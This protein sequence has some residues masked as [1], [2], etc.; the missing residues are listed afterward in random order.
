LESAKKS[1]KA[2]KKANESHEQDINELQK[3]LDTVIQR[4]DEYEEIISLET[5]SQ[6]SNMQLEDSKVKE[7]HRLKEEAGTQAASFLQEL[8]SL[9]REQKMDQDKLDN[10]M[11]KKNEHEAQIKQKEHELEECSQRTEKLNEYIRSSK[12][13]VEEQKK[14]EAT[15]AVDV[16]HARV[17][18][19]EIQT[20]LESVVEQLGEAKVDKHESARAVKR[21]ELIDNLKRLFP[22]VYGRLIDLCEPSHKKYQVAIT[23]VLGKYMDAIACDSEKTAKD[24]IQYMKEQ[25]IEPETFLPLDYV[26]VKPVNEKL[27]DINDPKNVKLVVDVIRYDPPCIKKALL[28]ACGNALVCETVEDAR[29]VAFN[30]SERHK[31][32]SLDGTLFQKSGVI[33]GGASDL[34]AKARRWDEKQLNQLKTKK[35]KLTDELKEQMKQKR[36]ESELNTIRSQI[37]GLET[38]LK[39][40]VTDRDNMQNKSIQQLEKD[41]EDNK[42]KTKSTD[43]EI[44]RIKELLAARGAKLRVVKDKMDTVEDRV[45][46]QFCRDINVENIRQYEERELQVQEE[47][48]QKR[49]EFDNQKERLSNQLEFEKSRD[50]YMN[51]KK[52]EESVAADEKELEKLRNDEHIQMQ[53]IDKDMQEQEQM[54]QAKL[55]AKSQADTVD[56]TMSEIRKRLSG[57]TKDVTAIQKTIT[58][59][60]IK[61][62]QKRADRH[63]LLKSCKMEGIHLP[64]IHGSMDDITQAETSSSQTDTAG[65]GDSMV[66]QGARAIYE[67]EARIVINYE[68]LK[69]DQTELNSSDDIKKAVEQLNKQISDMHSTLQHIT[70]PNMKA[71]EKL[72]H[73]KAKCQETSDEFET[74]RRR[75]KKC[76]QAFE[77]VRKERFDRFMKC[78]DHVSNSIDDIYKALSKNQSAQA[79]LGPE[80]AEEPYL[81]GINYNCVAPGKRFRPMDNLSGGEKTVAALA[82]LF[83][84]HSFQPAPFFVLD[85]VDAALDNTNIGKVAGYIKE[86]SQK[87]FQC[88][89]ISLKEEFYNRADALIGTYPEPAE[90]VVS[91]VLTIDLTRYADSDRADDHN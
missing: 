66:S 38:R 47:R 42:L 73:V 17:R 20:E 57:Q 14:L 79:F 27:R 60:E 32:V 43:P 3:E 37:K 35:E 50:T 90:C 44:A 26:E 10:E 16:D 83:A 13:A 33:S 56:G 7:Y 11:R 80:N 53:L 76:K 89:V 82:L 4:R 75:A 65:T 54:K 51:V 72:E 78:F 86:Q 81:D 19:G 62:E 84:I 6:G 88:I 12:V 41:L 71:T 61:L 87:N 31:S 64:M 8:D 59:V 30:L 74:A 1:L 46:H 29:K 77:K 9:S 25:R 5:A 48:A 2:A 24:C 22:G 21:A 40:S 58:S 36:K 39:Y 63:S 68:R 91:K 70:A 15:L 69:R 34:K 18:I 45:F 49:L 67:R 23:K 52:W 55:L 85:E 28:F